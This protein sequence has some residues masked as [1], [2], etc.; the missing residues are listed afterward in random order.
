MGN[1]QRTSRIPESPPPPYFTPPE[2]VSKALNFAGLSASMR[3]ICPVRRTWLRRSAQYPSSSSDVYP[4]V[5]GPSSLAD[6]EDTYLTDCIPTETNW[7]PESSLKD[8]QVVQ[9]T[10]Q[11]DTAEALEGG[12]PHISEENCDEAAKR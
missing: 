11:E 6:V 9:G 7:I 2:T 12:S 5:G 8:T 1:D 4:S 10:V 3:Q